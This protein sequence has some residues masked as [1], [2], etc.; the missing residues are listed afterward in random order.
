MI[1]GYPSVGPRIAIQLANIL[2]TG[3]EDPVANSAGNLINYIASDHSM[4]GNV[5]MG[6]NGSVVYLPA[7]SGTDPVSERAGAM[8]YNTSYATIRVRLA[9]GVWANV[10]TSA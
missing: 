5:V 1:V 3:E 7:K 8:Y 6:S 2:H 10:V 4:I 9:G